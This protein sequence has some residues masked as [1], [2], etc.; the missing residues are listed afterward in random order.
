MK[1][2]T[3]EERA[4]SCQRREQRSVGERLACALLAGLTAALVAGAL[5]AAASAADY[6][7]APN[8][9]CGG[10][11]VASFEQAL[12]LADNATDADRIFLGAATYT[13]APNSSGFDYLATGSPVEIVG[14]GEGHTIV[15]APAGEG[16]DFVLGVF[17]G[18]G[19]SVHDLTIRL[20]QNA[21][22]GAYGL[23]TDN[24]ARRIEVVEDPT[25]L[26][27]RTGIGLQHGAALEDSTVTLGSVQDT[28]AVALGPGG[29]TVRRSALSA[30][31]AVLSDYGGTIR[32]Q[33]DD[34]RSER[35]E[36]RRRRLRRP[37]RRELPPAPRLGAGRPRRPSHRAG[38]RPRRQPA[39]RGRQ[40]RRHRAPR[41]GRLRAPAGGARGRRRGPAAGGR[42]FGYP[43]AARQ[44][45]QGH[46]VRI[47]AR[48][49]IDA[50]RGA[51]PA[52][53]PLPLR[54]QRGRAR[55]A[56]DPARARRSSPRWQ[57]RAALPA[58]RPR[59]ALHALSRHRQALQERQGRRE[60]HP[61]QRQARQASAAAGRLSGG[62]PRRR[63]SRQPLHP[64]SHPLPG[65]HEVTPSPR[66]RQVAPST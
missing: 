16:S 55:Y 48:P 13:S 49:R 17:G 30:R 36:R 19:T 40:R 14:Q 64:A 8:T 47:R 33:R 12:D 42:V 58:A 46:P 18:P 51:A 56:D 37:G 27:R 23:M 38:A 60:R 41:P 59:Q 28:T 6:C 26:N 50:A 35:L 24:A 45:L 4:M 1:A 29:G 52:R 31:F 34:Q 54:A 53:H 39:R 21:A 25:Q 7:V 66:R 62:H 11:N 43:A 63:R 20:P 61:L 3:T 5:P 22:V 10:T 2:S 57:V 9:T 44:R 65:R 15:T 32:R